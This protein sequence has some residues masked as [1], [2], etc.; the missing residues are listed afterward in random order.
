MSI[1]SSPVIDSM[2]SAMVVRFRCGTPF[3]LAS[4]K[5]AT[6]F[7]IKF[8]QRSFWEWRGDHWQEAERARF[9]PKVQDV[10]A[11]IDALR[12][13]V[14]LR[15][16][17]NPMPGWFGAVGRPDG[18]LRELIACQNGLLHVPTRCLIPHS[19]RFWSANVLDFRY[20]PT[21]RAPRFERSLR[22]IFPDDDDA[23]GS[24]MEMFGYCLTDLTEFQ[25][26]FMF[27]TGIDT[28]VSSRTSSWKLGIPVR[29]KRCNTAI[30][31]PQKIIG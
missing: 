1:P 2:R 22:E 24:L 29:C 10:S 20:D 4:E 23:E 3:N 6:F 21:A 8:W 13:A 17:E 27:A 12:S 26:A 28:A 7:P 19:P 14:N 15:P 5:T 31:M 11:T 9:E 16:K 25:K 18:D 30:L